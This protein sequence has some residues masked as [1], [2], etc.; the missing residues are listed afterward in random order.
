MV[1]LENWKEDPLARSPFLVIPNL[2]RDTVAALRPD[3][4]QWRSSMLKQ[5]LYDE[6]GH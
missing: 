4:K 1:S 5:V 3:R 6:K 2:F